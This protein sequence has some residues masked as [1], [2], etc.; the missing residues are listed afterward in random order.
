[1]LKFI[2]EKI[3]GNQNEKELKRIAPLVEAVD[4][5]EKEIKPLTDAQLQAK[6]NMFRQKIIMFQSI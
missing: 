5:C 1:M 4:A 6:T 3:F 2:K